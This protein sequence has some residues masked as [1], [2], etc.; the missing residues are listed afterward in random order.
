MTSQ[1]FLLFLTTFVLIHFWDLQTA[2]KL[3]IARV[4]FT[5][6]VVEIVVT[7][8]F[9]GEVLL[10]SGD[11]RIINH[12]SKWSTFAKERKNLRTNFSQLGSSR[13]VEIVLT[14]QFENRGNYFFS[15]RDVRIINHFS[16]CSELSAKKC[17]N[18]SRRQVLKS[19][20]WVD[21]NILSIPPSVLYYEFPFFGGEG[22]K[23]PE[24]HTND[25][26]ADET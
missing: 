26:S 24:P 1:H 15:S 23:P 19:G 22:A 18:E 4:N 2:Y 5:L 10:S 8:L 21:S 6:N 16:K 9:E 20:G 3:F 7:I 17:K 25:G 11:V 14:V 12:L 13:V